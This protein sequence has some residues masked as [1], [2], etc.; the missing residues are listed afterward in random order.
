MKEMP[1]TAI[2]EY[3]QTNRHEEAPMQLTAQQLGKL[4]EMLALRESALREDLSREQSNLDDYQQMAGEVPDAGDQA[5]A[6][7]II[8]INHAEVNRDIA[9]LNEIAAAKERLD[10]NEYGLCADCGI[11]VPLERLQVQPTALR[12]VP[13]QTIREKTFADD[14]RGP[15]L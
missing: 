3:L 7:V 11:D 2:A 14:T 4:G 10:K 12:C 1:G 13:C 9:E 6:D 8:D 5:T 15:S